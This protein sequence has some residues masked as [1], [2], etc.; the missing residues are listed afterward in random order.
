VLVDEPCICNRQGN[1]IL[2]VV[3]STQSVPE[4]PNLPRPS[5]SAPEALDQCLQATAVT[6][7]PMNRSRIKSQQ[8]RPV[9]D[10][11]PVCQ[12]KIEVLAGVTDHQLNSS[13]SC[14]EYT[15]G[16]LIGPR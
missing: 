6:V 12:E 8:R 7:P 11:N 3:L 14:T 16:D 9:I 15:V 13:S 2:K 10:L 1:G 5:G 4:K